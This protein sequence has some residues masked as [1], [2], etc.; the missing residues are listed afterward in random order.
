MAVEDSS[1]GSKS[2]STARRFLVGSNVIVSILLVG[3]IAAVLQA[4]AYSGPSPVDMTSSRVNSLT[5]GTENLIRDLDVNVRLT[6]LY[7]ETDLEEEDQ[8]RYR[9][10]VSD[11]LDLY[12]STNRSSVAVDRINPLSDHEKYGKLRAGLL[13]KTAFK[14]ETAAYLEHISKFQDDLFPRMGGLVQSELGLL[15]GLGSAFGGQP[16]ASP[17]API[18]QVFE[19]WKSELQTAGERIEALMSTE[20][21]QYSGVLREIT[22]VYGSFVKTLKDVGAYSQAQ[23]AGAGQMPA[24]QAAYLREVSQRLSSLLS[25]IEE[26]QEQADGLEPLSVDDVFAQLGPTT[27]AILVETE[28]DA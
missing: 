23:I 22:S 11:L 6:S 3:G 9:R 4:M 1:A 14:A 13:E 16:A 17:T 20:I 27:N 19:Q 10:A 5:E 7:F 28:D 18:E 21:P 2:V 25:T 8:Q 24:S 15:S 12:E 26:E